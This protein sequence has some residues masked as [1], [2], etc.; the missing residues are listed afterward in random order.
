MTYYQFLTTPEGEIISFSR[1]PNAV[2]DIRVHEASDSQGRT[3]IGF[4]V[5][6]SKK[7]PDFLLEIQKF[8]QQKRAAE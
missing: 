8:I 5:D 6:E 2:G 7:S 1:V 3:S 4:F